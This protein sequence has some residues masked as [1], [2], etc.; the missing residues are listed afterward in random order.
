MQTQ[1]QSLLQKVHSL[2]HPHTLS[3]EE[4]MQAKD[5]DKR[6]DELE[7]IESFWEKVVNSY[8]IPTLK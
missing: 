7:W 1:S 2:A 4:R 6:R 8:F 3:W 5:P